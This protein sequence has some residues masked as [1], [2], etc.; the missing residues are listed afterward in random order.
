MFRG[1]VGVEGSRVNLEESFVK[2]FV[3]L[4]FR[5]TGEGYKRFV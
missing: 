3:A 2:V 5:I 4:F 1:A